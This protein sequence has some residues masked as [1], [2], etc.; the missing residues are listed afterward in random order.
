MSHALQHHQRVMARR[1]P[2][3][4]PQSNMA[5]SGPA[6]RILRASI[7]RDAKEARMR[8]GGKTSYKTRKECKVSDPFQPQS[9]SP[10][11][12][13]R[14]IEE[15]EEDEVLKSTS[16][17][18]Q[19]QR[20][21]VKT[22]LPFQRPKER[23]K[24]KA[25]KNHKKSKRIVTQQRQKKD[26]PLSQ[27]P[28]AVQRTRRGNTAL[29]R[30]ASDDHYS[31][32]YSVGMTQKSEST[33]LPNNIKFDV[34][35]RL[36]ITNNS[37]VVS[38]ERNISNG[39]SDHVGTENKED[40]AQDTNRALQMSDSELAPPQ[41]V[42]PSNFKPTKVDPGA[43][44]NAN[45]STSAR[46]SQHQTN[47]MA[48][49]PQLISATVI[50]NQS[51][52]SGKSQRR[53]RK[54]KRKRRRGLA[55]VEAQKQP[56]VRANTVPHRCEKHQSTARSHSINA[57]FKS[58]SMCDSMSIEY[59]PRK[60]NTKSTRAHTPNNHS[61]NSGTLT[62]GSPKRMIG[63]DNKSAAY[64][65][66]SGKAECD[67]NHP[68][69]N[70]ANTQPRNQVLEEI[71][72][73]AMLLATMK[74]DSE[75][76]ESITPDDHACVHCV[77]SPAQQYSNGAKEY[78][79]SMGYAHRSLSMVFGINDHNLES[80]SG[81]GSKSITVDNRSIDHGV[82]EFHLQS[83]SRYSSVN[84]MM[85]GNAGDLLAQRNARESI[86]NDLADRVSSFV[87][88]EY[89][90][91][92][93][94]KRSVDLQQEINRSPNSLSD[95]FAQL[96]STAN[97]SAVVNCKKHTPIDVKPEIKSL[98]SLQIALHE[99][100]VT[101]PPLTPGSLLTQFPIVRKE[102]KTTAD[103]Q[104]IYAPNAGYR[105][106]EAIRSLRVEA[107]SMSAHKIE[108]YG[109]ACL[110]IVTKGLRIWFDQ[111]DC[112]Q[113]E[114]QRQRI[115]YLAK[116]YFGDDDDI[117][118]SPRCVVLNTADYSRRSTLSQRKFIKES[119]LCIENHFKYSVANKLAKH[120]RQRAAR[121]ADDVTRLREQHKVHVQALQSN[122]ALE[123]WC[124]ARNVLKLPWLEDLD[125]YESSWIYGDGPRNKTPDYT[126]QRFTGADSDAQKRNDH[127]MALSEESSEE[128]RSQRRADVTNLASSAV[129][130]R[131]LTGDG[132]LLSK[133][134]MIHAQSQ[135]DYSE[136][137]SNKR[138][139][140]PVDFSNTSE[141]KI[142]S[143][144]ES[145]SATHK[146]RK[147]RYQKI[148]SE[149][150]PRKEKIEFIRTQHY[151]HR[152]KKHKSADKPTKIAKPRENKCQLVSATKSKKAKPRY[153][154]I[155]SERLPRKE[156]IELVRN[157]RCK[158]RVKKHKVAD[159]L[160][161]ITEPKESRLRLLSATK[162]TEASRV[163][164]N[165]Q[166][167]AE[168]KKSKAFDELKAME[169]K[170]V[171][172]LR[173]NL[174]VA[175]A[176]VSRKREHDYSEQIV[177]VVRLIFEGQCTGF[178]DIVLDVRRKHL[179]S[180]M[181]ATAARMAVGKLKETAARVLEHINKPNSSVYM[182][183]RGK[184]L[185]SNESWNSITWH[186]FLRQMHKGWNGK[187]DVVLPEV[188]ILISGRVC[189][190]MMSRNDRSRTAR[191]DH[192]T[193]F[194]QQ[195]AVRRHQHI[196]TAQA[197]YDEFV[198]QLSRMG[199]PRE[200]I[201]ILSEYCGNNNSGSIDSD[202]WQRVIK[203]LP[204]GTVVTSLDAWIFDDYPPSDEEQI[205]RH[206]V[207]TTAMVNK[208]LSQ[209]PFICSQL[210][211]RI[212]CV[213]YARCACGSCLSGVSRDA[214]RFVL[215][216]RD[217]SDNLE[218]LKD[219]DG[220]RDNVSYLALAS[221]LSV[222][223]VDLEGVFENGILTLI[224][225]SLRS[226]SSCDFGY[227]PEARRMIV[228]D[229]RDSHVCEYDVQFA[230]IRM[231]RQ[232]E[233]STYW[234]HV[235]DCE[236][237]ETELAESEKAVRLHWERGLAHRSDIKATEHGTA[238]H[239]FFD[240]MVNVAYSHK[241][242]T[243]WGKGDQLLL[244]AKWAEEYGEYIDDI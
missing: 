218:G 240:K 91:E 30:L 29:S 7:K 183:V 173:L 18:I 157:R 36:P 114:T 187:S 11:S 130:L 214:H 127:N 144:I 83:Q 230:L 163:I 33:E 243:R 123:D 49:K 58:D 168:R 120:H 155:A 25:S 196:D 131:V 45:D 89:K 53:I 122:M 220:R 20:K 8:K 136:N 165:N 210:G 229:M 92:S 193:N 234:T 176:K 231:Q 215:A 224:G 62:K 141:T 1:V 204:Y 117:V 6:L 93:I 59:V 16:R 46:N 10:Q 86:L 209:L 67:S 227:D 70:D 171:N 64:V 143:C 73:D 72:C 112:Q 12:T 52:V 54:E 119:M 51:G 221:G 197:A 145:Q 95:A 61:N 223:P 99:H 140:Q 107:L 79:H 24:R 242:M 40:E 172:K 77:S 142:G 9:L 169:R 34:A 233:L 104:L 217:R 208:F 113:G 2:Q 153:Q 232:N 181:S 212:K 158:H 106:S 132:R 121:V 194:E 228:E 190:G 105:I 68:F 226:G 98:T 138:E 156:K 237:Y 161:E 37:S 76:K 85:D 69:S 195:D 186:T 26:V 174:A 82:N 48:L 84:S 96:E 78:N 150:L 60:L 198:E 55:Q 15:V 115:Y 180:V 235:G 23:V 167:K 14:E 21:G 41:N 97:L 170:Q 31:N 189:G 19:L 219:Q 202:K 134:T 50:P 154:R 63:A 100:F 129:E 111:H 101:Y 4:A 148:A 222:V 137:L 139:P 205:E 133:D 199:I 159:R 81:L 126:A 128:D 206:I 146:T 28:A 151:G 244:A 27:M 17:Q 74:S 57:N 185:L 13:L 118:I 47:A 213:C 175:R 200:I 178:G 147:P 236:D 188:D 88:M 94:L 87:E 238:F 216:G 42:W 108:I 164:N 179:S 225:A 32:H 182:K 102:C 239:S 80:L 124:V 109:S 90:A 5:L 166:G 110:E 22:L 211:L 162:R 191:V 207:S 56:D 116:S 203:A 35:K 177:G 135:I 44:F 38:G 43:K 160:T 66:G 65:N 3:E 184:E 192:I 149:R 103:S 241:V 152:A 201:I 39:R 75:E 125:S 71:A